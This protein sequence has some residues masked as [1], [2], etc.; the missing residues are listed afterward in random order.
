MENQQKHKCKSQNIYGLMKAKWFLLLLMVTISVYSFSQQTI[1]GTVKDSSTGEALI[2]ATVM[3]E[4]TSIGTITDVEGNFSISCPDN[5]TLTFTYVGYSARNVKL[6]GN[7]KLNITLDSDSEILDDV[8]VI[9]YGVQKKESVVGA[10][11]Q[12]RSSDLMRSGV[13]NL[14]NSLAGR[15][16][17]MIT[18][19]PSGMPGANEPVIY[20]RGLSSFNG[21]N[22]PLVLVD[23]IERPLGNI[24]ASEVESVSVLKDASATAVYGV[25][26]GNGVILVTTKR[27]QEGRM[28]ISVSYD[29]TIKQPVNNGIQEDSYNTLYA[30]DKLY[31][32][33]GLYDR[34]LGPDI[35]ERY[36]NPSTIYEPY[37]Y[38]NADA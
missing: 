23:G 17:G 35:L 34:V 16:P 25:R 27:G 33:K 31:R 32:A 29:Q 20:I 6:T 21:D 22:Q 12:V 4:G 1:T 37:I 3:V 18:I 30:R 2:G 11:S 38:P 24:D 8:V 9:A 26:G 28:E 15:V 10:I 13:P 14:S 7:T 36:R 5:A 19:Q